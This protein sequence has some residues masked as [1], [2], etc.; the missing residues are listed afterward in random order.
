MA[1]LTAVER[2]RVELSCAELS[3]REINAALRQLPD[4]TAVR[5]T[6][7]RGQHNLAVGLAARLDITICG[8]AGYFTGGLGDGPD[9]TVE[10]FTGWSAGENLHVG[11]AAGPRQRVG[12]GRL[13]R[14]TAA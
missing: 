13:P 14:R 6:E 12:I 4:G 5:L 8:N 10:G 7:A 2:S 11:H 1:S 9:I 3:V